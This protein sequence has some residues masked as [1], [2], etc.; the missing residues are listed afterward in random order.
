M[1][2]IKFQWFLINFLFLTAYQQG[3]KQ[4]HNTKLPSLAILNSSKELN[5]P[6]L[7]SKL[8]QKYRGKVVYLDAWATWCGPCI[9]GM[10]AS[11]KLRE[12]LKGED[13]VFVYICMDSPNEAGWKNIISAKNIEGENYF[14]NPSQSAILAK[15]LEINSIP[16]YTLIDKNGSI[17]NTTAPSPSEPDAFRFIT[18]LLNP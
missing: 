1:G 10:S 16:H 14:L 5:G 7:L 12:K 13:V 17:V 11:E 3:L 8:L 4:L 2:G 15:T 6:D 9:A 18:K